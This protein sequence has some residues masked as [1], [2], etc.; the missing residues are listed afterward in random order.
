MKLG[1]TLARSCIAHHVPALAGKR[2]ERELVV[3][4]F[5]KALVCRHISRLLRRILCCFAQSLSCCHLRSTF[6]WCLRFAALPFC[7]RRQELHFVCDHFPRSALA[8]VL[9]LII[10]RI[11]RADH[12]HLSTFF[13]EFA[14]Q[15][16]EL[17]PCLNGKEIRIVGAGLRILETSIDRNGEFA[18][19]HTALCCAHLRR[20]DNVSDQMNLIHV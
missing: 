16:C 20:M 3:C 8:A 18:H 19:I 15:V 10:P 4:Y 6:L 11:H 5:G 7:L 2:L 12:G 1:G 17:P 9:G 14:A 13:K